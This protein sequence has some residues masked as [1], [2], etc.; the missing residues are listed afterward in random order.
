MAKELFKIEVRDIIRDEIIGYI[1]VDEFRKWAT[2]RGASKYDF[3]DTII[4]QF[5][6]WKEKIREP[7]RV[8]RVEL[9]DKQVYKVVYST[10]ENNHEILVGN[11]IIV[12]AKNEK[13]ARK[14][15]REYLKN[16]Y[17]YTAW[18]IRWITETNKYS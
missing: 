10:A 15:A 9:M 7:E 13:D 8:K 4:E 14:Q 5:N 1:G 2:S 11:S 16:R 6:D 17:P 18:K 3:L 12:S